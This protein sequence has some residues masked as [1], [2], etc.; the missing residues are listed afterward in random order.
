MGIGKASL[1]QYLAVMRQRRVL[2]TRKE[3]ASVIYRI[4]SSKLIAACNIAR[5]ALIDQLIEG[6]KTRKLLKAQDK[7]SGSEG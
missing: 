7:S 6:E 2:A 5:E 3:G 4:A 1:A